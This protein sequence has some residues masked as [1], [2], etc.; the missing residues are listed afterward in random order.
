MEQLLRSIRHAGWRV[1]IHNDYQMEGKWYTFW[2]FTHPN[3][4]WIRGEGQTDLEAL[5]KVSVDLA[6]ERGG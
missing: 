3:G 5:E 6:E 1:A 4:R 2:L